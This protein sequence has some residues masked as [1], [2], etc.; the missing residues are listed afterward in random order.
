MR[1]RAEALEKCCSVELS[2]M[3][4]ISTSAHLIWQLLDT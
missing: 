4:E 2:A 3:I 1:D